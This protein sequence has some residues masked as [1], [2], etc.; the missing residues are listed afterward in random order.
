ME[1]FFNF[2]LIPM[3]KNSITN[4]ITPC[5]GLP[6][7]VIYWWVSNLNLN[8]EADRQFIISKISQG[9]IISIDA[10]KI[11]I[12]SG[13][14][15]A[16]ANLTKAEFLAWFDCGRQPSCEQLKLIIENFKISNYNPADQYGKGWTEESTFEEYGEKIIKKITGYV[17]GVGV[18]P[19]ELSEHI[20][21][22]YAA[23]GGYTT[24][25]DLATDFKPDVELKSFREV[26]PILKTN[27]SGLV[28]TYTVYYTDNTTS[29]FTV[30]N[31][32][33]VE[34]D[35]DGGALSYETA[36][37]LLSGF[38]FGD[39]TQPQLISIPN[40]GV[41]YGGHF[42]G[43]DNTYNNDGAYPE[44]GVLH[45][46][47]VDGAS[48][49]K[50][51]NFYAIGA[52]AQFAAIVGIKN[53]R[54]VVLMSTMASD[55]GQPHEYDMTDFETVSFQIVQGNPFPTLQ[56]EKYGKYYG[57]VKEYVDDNFKVLDYFLNPFEIVSQNLAM[58]Q[59]NENDEA[60][61]N[62]Q[63]QQ[64]A[65]AGKSNG[66]IVV[67][68]LPVDFDTLE[69]EGNFNVGGGGTLWLGGFNNNTGVYDQLLFG[70]AGSGKK[71]F[72]IN[73][74]RYDYYA[75]SRTDNNQ[76]YRLLK[77]VQLQ[78]EKD[79]VK[80]YIDN[81]VSS[82]SAISNETKAQIQRP[83]KVLRLEFT[84][85]DA[86]PVDKTTIASGTFVITDMQGLGVKKF[87]TMEVQGSSSAIHPKKNWTLALFNDEAKTDSF[88]LRVGEWAEHSEFVFKANWI[89]ATHARNLISN[90]IWEDIVQSR[91]GYP[92]R[93]NE[94]AYVE[95]Y[96]GQTQ[97]F[98]SGALT[99]VDGVPC[100]LYINGGFYGIGC[101]NLG[102][103]RENYDLKSGTQNHIQLAAETHANFYAYNPLEWEIRNPKT[104]D[105]NFNTKVNA[106]FAANALT[107]Q[108]FKDNFETN[109]DL[110]NA[111]DFYLLAEFI[112][113]PDMYTKN[114]MLTSWDG[115]KFY[116]LPYDMDT[117]FGLQWD[118]LSFTGWDIS[119][120]SAGF[121]NK[122]YT[123]Y[124]P[125]IKARYAELKAKGIFSVDN[126]YK[127]A[128]RINKTFG[129]ELFKKEQAAWVSVPSNSTIYTGYPQIYDW[130]KNRIIWLDS[131]YV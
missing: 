124:T 21:K 91:V 62:T 82:G 94:I 2:K 56:F 70:V 83:E 131:R 51:S 76:K 77:T 55:G 30:A 28:D 11:L 42:L 80:T 127:H 48:K 90:H 43:N 108:A 1:G 85:T 5:C 112:Q 96:T 99:H 35:V 121:W 103:K 110:K 113:S 60:I 24:D 129:I 118:G 46:V 109:H 36:M 120:R 49:L 81:H 6:F 61:I 125:K 8:S 12:N 95:S 73:R 78:K 7:S 101:F 18:L 98:D 71:T 89:D 115:I 104:P 19:T 102:K 114:L 47:P 65:A 87:G 107:G 63:W 33:D 16:D 15:E 31:G 22:Y 123:A 66:V 128:D 54:P 4:K 122:F 72:T 26:D 3:K 67:A 111:I 45:N 41:L 27:T 20:G 32:E 25:K 126:V 105:S 29:T 57:D 10:W 100:E 52:G 117:T 37:E 93:E 14:L 79:S 23:A 84:T 69:I 40:S 88:K 130:V 86:I 74:S 116:F 53:G 44:I 58:P 50:V 68:D 13:T 9:G 64:Y 59:P 34:L 38:V 75:Y 119:I 106:W 17:G 92:K 39:P 97:R